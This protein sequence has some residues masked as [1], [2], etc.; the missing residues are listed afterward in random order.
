MYNKILIRYG[1]LSL[2]GK[3]KMSFVR[4]LERNMN[5][6]HSLFPVTTFDRMYLDYSKENMEQLRFVT[7]IS[8]YSP[9]REVETTYENI[10]SYLKEFCKD[11]EGTFKISARR[12]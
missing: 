4:Q 6:I 1:E 11:K 5:K 10:K 3:N 12:S 9:V 2:K 7:G 8:S